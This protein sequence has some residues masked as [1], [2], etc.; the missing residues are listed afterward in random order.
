MV[1]IPAET[2]CLCTSET[3]LPIHWIY[4]EGILTFL[5]LYSHIFSHH[6]HMK[7]KQYI[8]KQTL[9]W[10]SHRG[11]IDATKKWETWKQWY[12]S[13][14]M[15][16]KSRFTISEICHIPRN[17]YKKGWGSVEVCQRLALHR[18]PFFKKHWKQEFWDKTQTFAFKIT[19]KIW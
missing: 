15:L 1:T 11:P 3:L 6:M 14:A 10:A 16:C 5:P 2:W 19:L 9:I 7:F 13:V 8:T 4:A 17:I 18:Y 12:Q